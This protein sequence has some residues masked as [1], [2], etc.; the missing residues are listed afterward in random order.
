MHEGLASLTQR[1]ESR[2]VAA[3]LGQAVSAVA[4]RVRAG[5]EPPI[6]SVASAGAAVGGAD[7]GDV[8][9]VH[10][11]AGRRARRRASFPPRSAPSVVT[12]ARRGR[13]ARVPSCSRTRTR[14]SALMARWTRRASAAG[15]QSVSTSS[16]G[17]D[18]RG[19]DRCVCALAARVELERATHEAAH[20]LAD[21]RCVDL[22]GVDAVQQPAGLFGAL[23]RVLGE[24]AGDLA[25]LLARCRA[26]GRRAA[27]PVRCARRP[28]RGATGTETLGDDRAHGLLE[29]L[30]RE[31]R[32]RRVDL[33]GVGS[34]HRAVQS[35]QHVQ[36]HE[37][38]ALVLGDLDVRRA[39]LQRSRSWVISAS[40]ASTRGR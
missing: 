2:G 29:Q 33:V 26:G 5:S 20:V 19:C 30:A 27:A 25:S 17:A 11:L 23:G 32:R 12:A 34:A 13:C 10:A 3:A 8:G 37:P 36:V 15:F 1:L 14:S 18:G 39:H 35:R 38:A 7:G 28:A 4:E 40:R 9:Q 16:T 24:V 31:P 6:A 21:R 22:F